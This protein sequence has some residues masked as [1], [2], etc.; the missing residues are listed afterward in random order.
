MRQ[1]T[2][3]APSD[4]PKWGIGPLLLL[5]CALLFALVSM[6]SAVHGA[7]LSLGRSTG[8]QAWYLVRISGL[9]AYY[10]LWA[11]TVAGLLVSGRKFKRPDWVVR[12]TEWHNSFTMAA[13][14][15][16]FFHALMLL[17][18]RYIGF[19][20]AQVFVPF[21][22]QYHPLLMGLGSLGLYVT[23]LLVVTSLLRSRMMR[24]WRGLHYLSFPLYLG[25]TLHAGLLGTDGGTNAAQWA[26][27]IAGF[28]VIGLTLD[29]VNARWKDKP[30]E[31]DEEEEE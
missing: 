5:V 29:R 15:V 4:R 21:F 17:A 26:M 14:Y 22:G 12:T 10:L 3:S 23:L 30:L 1:S 7:A 20:V 9:L 18:D 31:E 16:G 2:N 24:L 11:G 28:L 13:L 8:V 6:V 19:N 27:W 25:L